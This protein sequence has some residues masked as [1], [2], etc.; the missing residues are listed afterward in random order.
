MGDN[1]DMTP[2]ESFSHANPIK[3]FAESYGIS[4]AILFVCYV[5]YLVKRTQCPSGGGVGGK[6]DH[7][8]G[9]SIVRV[10]SGVISEPSFN[11][12][13]PTLSSPKRS[14]SRKRLGTGGMGSET[15]KNRKMIVPNEEVAGVSFMDADL[16]LEFMPEDEDRPAGKVTR[17]ITELVLPTEEPPRPP[18][19]GRQAA[20]DDD[21]DEEKAV[22]H[23]MTAWRSLGT[24]PAGNTLT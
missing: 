20:D 10:F 15:P 4:L 24:K 12:V 8:D 16:S 22:G 1:S 19:R 18:G 5:A 23:V 7:R 14:P 11:G 3:M 21:D 13:A 6:E 17:Q 9:G 2:L